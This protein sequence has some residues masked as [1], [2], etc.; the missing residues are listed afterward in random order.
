CAVRDDKGFENEG[1]Q[2]V[3]I[4]TYPRPALKQWSEQNNL[5]VKVLSDF[6]PHG[7]TAQAYGCFNEQLGVA[8]RASYV[9]DEN[10]VVREIIRT[11]TLPE[12][13]DH[14]LYKKA[15]SAI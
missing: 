10:G 1:A 15:L 7:A 12:K 2:T 8:M 6:W 9:L 13:R 4:T 5:G 3:I 14:D 11:D